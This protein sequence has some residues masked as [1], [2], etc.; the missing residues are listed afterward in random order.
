M[1]AIKF[2]VAAMAMAFAMNANA[3]WKL[4]LGDGH[5]SVNANV[6]SYG[7]S[8][9]GFGLGAT[10]QT[11]VFTCDWLS[12]DWDVLHFE[13]DAPFSSPGD[14]DALNFK[15]GLRAYSPSFANDHLR[16]Y[17]N[18]AM[19]YVLGIASADGTSTNHN[20][21]LDYGIGLQLNKKWSLGYTLEFAKNKD[22]KGK[23]HY[24]TVAYTF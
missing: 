20:F 10:Y 11:E 18:L 8:T 13:W 17:T 21:G 2:L 16:A 6:G 23:S 7:P 24:A 5:I 4:D 22:A 1:K 3:E 9:A 15:T 19:G 12:L 14:A